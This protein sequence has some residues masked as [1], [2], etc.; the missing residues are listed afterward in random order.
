MRHTVAFLAALAAATVHAAPIVVQPGTA[1]GYMYFPAQINVQASGSGGGGNAAP[2]GIGGVYIQKMTDTAPYTD[3]TVSTTVAGTTPCGAGCTFANFNTGAGFVTLTAS[4][5]SIFTDT[6]NAP[7][8]NCSAVT[9]CV[10]WVTPNNHVSV[11]VRPA[12]FV[13]DITTLGAQTC[14][15][16]SNT[17]GANVVYDT[18]LS[19]IGRYAGIVGGRHI[20]AAATDEGSYAWGLS[21]VDSPLPNIGSAPF[22]LAPSASDLTTINSLGA[23]GSYPAFAACYNKSPGNGVWRLPYGAELQALYAN[24][25]A[26]GG[27]SSSYYWSSTEYN[28]DHAWYLFFTNGGQWSSYSKTYTYMPVRCVRSF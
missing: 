25:S 18:N 28:S 22:S 23:N 19:P 10:L 13:G 14:S 27:F 5:P 2:T 4:R 7:F 15:S 1:A 11:R 20:V 26:I 8:P 12:C 17:A 16:T 6:S 3:Y 21:P 24:M 9:Q